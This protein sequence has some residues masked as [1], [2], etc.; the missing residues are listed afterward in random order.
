MKISKYAM[1]AFAVIIIVIIIMVYKSHQERSNDKPIIV[2]YELLSKPELAENDRNYIFARHSW[3]R[4]DSSGR[5][6][7]MDPVQKTIKVFD[8][9]FKY[10][11]SVGRAGQGPGE[12]SE[13][14]GIDID[15]N[16]YLYVSDAKLMKII[17]YD[18]NHKYFNEIKLK[19]VFR[20]INM[21]VNSKGDIYVTNSITDNIVTVYN[22]NGA[23]TNKFGAINGN[24]INGDVNTTS[25]AID[26]DDNVW[27]AFHYAPIVR[28]YDC[29]GVLLK[30][31]NVLTEQIS[32]TKKKEI[33]RNDSNG[34]SLFSYL[35]D[36]VYSNKR[37]Y[38]TNHYYIISLDPVGIKQIGTYMINVPD[39]SD[40]YNF[41]YKLSD[42]R[43][44]KRFYFCS[45][46]TGNIYKIVDQIN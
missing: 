28:K 3:I 7:V 8:T 13:P 38:I 6:Y 32:K 16:N 41:I 2:N 18:N 11:E 46:P 37:I 10:I 44:D 33:S 35:D 24:I 36:I 43:V 45:Q 39:S 14:C 29:N 26:K 23:I 5:L 34:S 25:I 9:N 21:A 42:N 19:N 15:R 17:I 12:M 1:V 40:K 27:L 4:N 30:E 20:E 22:K 31:L